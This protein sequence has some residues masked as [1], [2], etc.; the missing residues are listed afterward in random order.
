MKKMQAGVLGLVLAAGLAAS[1]MAVA[2][3]DKP[4]A[5]AEK[6]LQSMYVSFLNGKGFAKVKVD[7]D[8]DVAFRDADFG[9]YIAVDEKDSGYFQ[10]VMPGIWEIESEGERARA[11]QAINQTNR[12]VKAAKLYIVNDNIWVSVEM[13]VEKPEDFKAVFDRSK[14]TLV[15]AAKIYARAMHAS[16]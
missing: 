2:A 4:A 10:M 14:E 1:G 7:D 12:Q 8:G 11:V 15:G 5:G 6:A 9:F 3:D 13:F 16:E